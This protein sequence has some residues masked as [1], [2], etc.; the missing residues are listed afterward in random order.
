[1]Y[2]IAIPLALVLTCTAAPA[3]AQRV[4]EATAF[5]RSLLGT[6]IP[7]GAGWAIALASGG[8]D[9]SAVAGLAGLSFTGGL[10]VGPALGYFH[11]G[12]PGRAWAGIGA[13]VLG[14]GAM[15]GALAES[16]ECSGSECDPATAVYVA[17]SILTIGSASYDIASVKGAVRRQNE[18]AGRMSVSV[19]PRFAVGRV[20]VT[21]AGTVR[22]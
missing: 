22:L 15:V 13:R 4:S 6:V 21:V 5:Q 9:N 10:I 16:W 3:A 12:K 11:A 8:D 1:M 20:G 2:C 7:M 19:G 18:A 14:L 17:G